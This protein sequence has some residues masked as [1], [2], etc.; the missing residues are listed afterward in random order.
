MTKNIGTTDRIVRIAIAITIAVLYW[1][2]MLAG[3][4]AFALLAVA[5]M[6]VA[7]SFVRFCGLYT[8][9]GITTCP[10]K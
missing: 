3:A 7:T 2:D 4:L 8:I 6:L 10:R 1:Q 9:L 5:V